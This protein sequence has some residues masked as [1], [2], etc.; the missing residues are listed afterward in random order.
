MANYFEQM[1]AEQIKIRRKDL[2]LPVGEH[3]IGEFINAVLRVETEAQAK[4]FYAGYLAY[5]S[6]YHPGDP[7][8][9]E[10]VA[11]SNI[12]WCFGEGMAPDRVAMWSRI[13]G[14]SHPVFGSMIPSPSQAFSLGK[15]HAKREAR[16]NG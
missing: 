12:G 11:R 5:Q 15:K 16:R 2:I 6:G 1:I 14:A 9:D 13:V 3:T 4:E 10:R 8:E 7:K